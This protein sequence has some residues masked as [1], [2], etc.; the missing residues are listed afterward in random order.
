VRTQ[1][2]VLRRQHPDDALMIKDAV[3][4]SLAH[5]QASVAW[6]QSAP[7]PLPILTARLAASAQA[8]DAGLAWAFTILDAAQTRVLGGAGLE[9]AEPALTALVGRR[10][11]ENGY[12]LRAD[13]IGQGYATE[14]TRCLVEQ[15]FSRLAAQRV[16]ICHDPANPASEGVP[17]RLGFRCLGEVSQ[18]QLPGRRAANG[19]V[20][21]AS[22]VWVLDGTP[23][24]Q[25]D[26]SLR[27]G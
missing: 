13:A 14:A 17:R 20:R 5:L 15:A 18:A 26:P 7:E 4:S 25:A 2:L 11:I 24:A 6:A 9:P 10:A 12:W 23:A 8:F 27:S 3:D 22:K 16:V 21:A 19:S 1:R